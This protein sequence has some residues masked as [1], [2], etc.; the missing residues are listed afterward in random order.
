MNIFQ[1]PITS[2]RPAE[3]RATH[4]LKPD[5]KLLNASMVEHGWIYPIVVRKN[6]MKIIDGFHRW[7]IASENDQFRKLHGKKTLPAVLADV[8]LIDAMVMHIRLNRTRG[9]LVARHLGMLVTDILKSQKYERKEVRQMLTMT[10]DELRVLLD[11]SLLKHRNISEY[12]YSKAW[13]PV[14]V[15]AGEAVPSVTFETPPNADR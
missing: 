2:V 6:D 14:E 5:F 7:L 9:Q 12:E 4:M 8:D 1:V 10:E 11:G 15:A 13:I 3:Y